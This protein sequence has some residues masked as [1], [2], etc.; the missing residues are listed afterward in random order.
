MSA[1]LLRAARGPSASFFR[2]NIIAAARPQPLAARA[3][4]VAPSL[5]ALTASPSFSTSSR[6]RSEHQEETFEEFTAR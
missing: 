1:T 2:A 3:G 6:L 5:L 4:L